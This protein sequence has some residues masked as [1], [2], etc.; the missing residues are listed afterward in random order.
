MLHRMA[1]AVIA[2]M[3][4]AL[5]AAGG[6]GA[7]AQDKTAIIKQRQALMKQQAAALKVIQNYVSGGAD[8]DTAT[9]KAAELLT[10]PPQITG[11]F[12]P[13]T[14]IVDFPGATHAK[15]E[16]WEQWDRFKDVPVV[17]RRAEQRLADAIRAGN[18]QDV[19]DELDTVGRTGCGACHT[20]FRAPLDD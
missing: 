13:G 19:L 3:L 4:G 17:L 1:V 12:P 11:L 14:S 15:P 20:Y 10:L 9:A 6:G 2:G 7:H 16:I 5:L 18:K 8:R